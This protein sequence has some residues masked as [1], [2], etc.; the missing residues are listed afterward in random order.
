MSNRSKT[1]TLMTVS[2]VTA[3]TIGAV[4]APSDERKLAHAALWG[5]LSAASTGALGLFIFDED[6]KRHEAETKAMK[7]EKELAAMNAEIAPELIAT[8]RLGLSKPL[9]E[10]FKNLIT[11]GEWSLYHV[12]RWGRAGESELVHQD[13]LFRFHQPQLNPLGKPAISEGGK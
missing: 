13:L 4:L 8:N 7:L 12:D 6:A 1:L 5:G 11:P 9:P 2:A 3:G 10:K